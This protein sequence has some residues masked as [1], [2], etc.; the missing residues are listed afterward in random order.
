MAAGGGRLR[1]AAARV[2]PAHDA[3]QQQRQRRQRSTAGQQGAL[4]GASS[5]L[6]SLLVAAAAACPLQQEA[7]LGFHNTPDRAGPLLP[8]A[9]HHLLQL[10]NHF[11]PSDSCDTFVSESITG[12]AFDDTGSQVLANYLGEPAVWCALLLHLGCCCTGLWC[13]A[14]CCALLLLRSGCFHACLAAASLALSAY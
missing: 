7:V 4:Q 2:R 6:R 14:A 9:D 8:A 12:V 1:H 5:Q 11:C 3:G 13:V 10:V